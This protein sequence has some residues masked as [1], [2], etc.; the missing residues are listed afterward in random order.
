MTEQQQ[1]LIH[2]LKTKVN[3][4]E[5]TEGALRA[6]KQLLGNVFESMQEGVLVLDN[7][8][9]YTHINRTLEEISRTKKEEILGKIPWEIFPFLKGDVEEA[10]KKAMRGEISRNIE[11]KYTLFDGKEGWTTESYFPLKDSEETIVGVVGVIDDI[12]ERK[13]AES[14]LKKIN[15]TLNAKNEEL[16]DFIN[17]ASHDFQEPLRKV[18]LFS[19]RL[20]EEAEGISG[21][22]LQ[23]IGRLQSAVE[24]MQNLMSDLVLYSNAVTDEKKSVQVVDLNEI[25][26]EILFDFEIDLKKNNGKVEVSTLSPIES[27]SFQIKRLIHNLISNSLKY[28]KRGQA[29]QI[30][31]EGQVSSSREDLYEIHFQDNGIGFDEKFKSKIFKPFKRLHRKD[32]FAGTGLGLTLCQKIVERHGGE[33]DVKSKVG[34]GATFIIKIPFK[35]S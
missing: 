7:D 29:P 4:L 17:F 12:T 16:T 32:E 24:R 28:N 18:F 31:I 13:Q 3:A 6:S 20:K 14:A 5:D 23:Y 8:F 10:I 27:D 2:S 19:D 1:N 9:K 21:K 22:G 33:I 34:E 30:K 15:H 11:L 35:Q 25:I 26:Q